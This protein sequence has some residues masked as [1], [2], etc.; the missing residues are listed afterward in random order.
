MI[1]CFAPS[2]DF[3]FV[4]D[5]VQANQHYAQKEFFIKSELR[6]LKTALKSLLLFN[7]VTRAVIERTTKVDK[8]GVSFVRGVSVIICAYFG[9]LVN[10]K[11]ATSELLQLFSE[12]NHFEMDASVVKELEPQNATGSIKIRATKFSND[13]SFYP[14]QF[15]SGQTSV[16]EATLSDSGVVIHQ[17]TEPPKALH[18]RNQQLRSASDKVK[19]IADIFQTVSLPVAS[20]IATVSSSIMDLA[21]TET[22]ILDVLLRSSKGPNFRY[23]IEIERN[24]VEDQNL[25]LFECLSAYFRSCPNIPDKHVIFCVA[26]EKPDHRLR[27]ISTLK[28]VGPDDKLFLYATHDVAAYDNDFSLFDAEFFSCYGSTAEELKVQ[29]DIEKE[30]TKQKQEETKQLQLL[31][32]IAKVTT[33]QFHQ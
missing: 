20:S 33:G 22:L 21:V 31:L 1:G 27:K 24:K 12:S 26:I 10:E 3:D 17:H 9:T 11:S 6:G 28:E 23:T 4:M 25:N 16:A 15:S 18:T 5:V 30:K 2:D 7:G 13:D 19:I 14:R 29:L 32:E 8:D